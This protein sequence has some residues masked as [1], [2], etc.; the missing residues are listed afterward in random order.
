MQKRTTPYNGHAGDSTARGDVYPR[1]RQCRSV[2][3]DERRVVQLVDIVLRVVLPA[4]DEGNNGVRYLNQVDELAFAEAVFPLATTLVRERWFWTTDDHVRACLSAGA[5]RVLLRAFRDAASGQELAS[6]REAL[7]HRAQEAFESGSSRVLAVVRED[8][9]W[10]NDRAPIVQLY[11][12]CTNDPEDC[13]ARV[14]ARIAVQPWFGILRHDILIKLASRGHGSVAGRIVA[15]ELAACGSGGAARD[16]FAKDL[17][18]I[19]MAQ[20]RASRPMDE[21][22]RVVEVCEH[23]GV[24]A[25]ECGACWGDAL[26]HAATMVLTDPTYDVDDA[27]WLIDNLGASRATQQTPD[28]REHSGGPHFLSYAEGK[29]LDVRKLVYLSERWKNHWTAHSSN[30]SFL[31]AFLRGKLDV[32]EYLKPT[33]VGEPRKQRADILCTCMWRCP[34][35][36]SVLW[37]TRNPECFADIPIGEVFRLD[38]RMGLLVE[39]CMHDPQFPGMMSTLES[40]GAFT[41]S[42]IA[43]YIRDIIAHCARCIESTDA[44]LWLADVAGLQPARLFRK[45]TPQPPDEPIPGIYRDAAR[46]HPEWFKHQQVCYLLVRGDLESVDELARSRPDLVDEVA[47]AYSACG[48]WDCT[49]SI[50][51][52]FP[53]CGRWGLYGPYDTEGIHRSWLRLVPWLARRGHPVAHIGD[54]SMR[55]CIPWDSSSPL[56]PE[57]VAAVVHLLGRSPICFHDE[58]RR[59]LSYLSSQGHASLAGLLADIVG[60]ESDV[61]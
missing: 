37:L 5:R 32:L 15:G 25:A 9:L 6:M 45:M 39:G 55:G 33:W 40:L 60:V 21:V 49:Q 29:C 46:R 18:A 7:P 59:N 28:A 41:R 1:K 20:V 57:E 53:R 4:V 30:E 51:S 11:A 16:G 54:I 56:S 19:M 2:T 61:T 14:M 23:A 31:G 50:C 52:D 27:K 26:P 36:A 34:A 22:R 47:R 42:A 3:G 38:G 17:C 35:V 13:V 12:T 58:W 48:A 44:L 43:D 24:S 8:L 10:G